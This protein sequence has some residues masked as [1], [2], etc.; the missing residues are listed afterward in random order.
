MLLVMAI[1]PP[2]VAGPYGHLPQLAAFGHDDVTDTSNLQAINMWAGN[3]PVGGEMLSLDDLF[4]MDDL[5]SSN[6]IVTNSTKLVPTRNGNLLPQLATLLTSKVNVN[7]ASL[8]RVRLGDSFN[9]N[10]GV[11]Q[12]GVYLYDKFE[13]SKAA[14][15]QGAGDTFPT[16]EAQSLS[17]ATATAADITDDRGITPVKSSM[18]LFVGDDRSV[19]AQ[20]S[21]KSA[22]TGLLSAVQT[23]ARVG[24]GVQHAFKAVENKW[25][26]GAPTQLAVKAITLIQSPIS[27]SGAAFIAQG[28]GI[29]STAVKGYNV[30]SSHVFSGE[31]AGG[32]VEFSAAS[33]LANGVYLYVV[34]VKGADGQSFVSKVQK[35]IIAH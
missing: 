9:L 16:F 22:D 8:S 17:R 32:R 13:F 23:A 19:E 24:P 12:N 34:T 28:A 20:L 14:Q 35:L 18:A 15:G 27:G 11:T 10:S 4:N 30:A 25:I 3:Q 31:N 21:G 5:W 2:T 26:E 6:S 1:A 29:A 7:Q 33:T